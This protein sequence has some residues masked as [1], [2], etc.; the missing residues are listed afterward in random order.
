ML[1]GNIR[2][3]FSN[4]ICMFIMLNNGHFIAVICVIHCY[5]MGHIFFN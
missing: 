4:S 3:Y 5:N 1:L 2:C